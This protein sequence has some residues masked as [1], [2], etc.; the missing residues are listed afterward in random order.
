M[1]GIIYS[2][3]NKLNNKIY[4]GLTSL[5]LEKRKHQHFRDTAYG[6]KCYF[7]N[8]IRK[9][10]EACFS[11]GVI[12]K[13]IPVN[14]LGDMEKLYIDLFDT[15]NTG[16]NSTMGGDGLSYALGYSH[17]EETKHKISDSSIGKIK[18]EKTRRKISDS[19]I[20]RTFSEETQ[21]KLSILRTGRIVSEAT[22]RK[23][24]IANTGKKASV[25]TLRKMSIVQTG[26]KVSEET[27]KKISI[28]NGK[29]VLQFTREGKFI[30]MYSSAQIANKR[31]GV[32]YSGISKTCLNKQLT[33]GGYVWK[34]AEVTP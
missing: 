15:Y 30:C 26:K 8:A 12:E 28:A 31:T 4:I 20:G 24:S 14:K 13:D 3:R 1:K 25:D 23:I 16:Y 18:S 6:S 5:T 33:A 27:R 2:A 17:T 10:G 22:R 11:W 32:F 34:F 9:Y 29:G 19:S 7:H 21:K